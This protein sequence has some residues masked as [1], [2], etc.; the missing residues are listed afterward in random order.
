MKFKIFIYD[1]ERIYIDTVL[2]ASSKD[3]AEMQARRFLVSV[4]ANTNPLISVTPLEEFNEANNW[5]PKGGK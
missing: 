2:E 1:N 4:P 5:N 3:A